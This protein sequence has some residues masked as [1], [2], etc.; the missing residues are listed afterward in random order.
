M[1]NFKFWILGEME[2]FSFTLRN[3]GVTKSPH[4]LAITA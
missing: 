3:Y 1:L 4:A 2:R